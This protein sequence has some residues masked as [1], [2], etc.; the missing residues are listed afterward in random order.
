[1]KKIF[2]IL[3]CFILVGCVSTSQKKS[4]SKVV[5]GASTNNEDALIAELYADVLESKG[6]DVDR[7]YGLSEQDIFNKLKGNKINI[8]FNGMENISDYLQVGS[9]SVY[10]DY[11]EMASNKI[12]S[13]YNIRLQSYTKANRK[14]SFVMEKTNSKKFNVSKLS[15]LKNVSSKLVVGVDSSHSNKFTE[16]CELYGIKDWDSK[17]VVSYKKRYR[18]MLDKRVDIVMGSLNDSPIK[19]KRYV[20]LKDDKSYCKSNPCVLMVNQD[21]LKN[22][23]KVVSYWN[24]MKNK[25]T[26]K[27]LSTLNNQMNS[28]GLSIED[29]GLDNLM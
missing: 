21:Y 17:S 4:S 3:L 13:K 12:Q 8:A 11:Y 9:N 1:M 5:I 19:S 18:K 23:K 29:M 10:N 14:I 26:D 24:V 2:A 15:E 28:K 25:I 27:K 16:L 6:Y 7:E 20:V 22:N